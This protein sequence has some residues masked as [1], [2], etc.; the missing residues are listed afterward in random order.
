MRRG[1]AP[2]GAL[3]AL[4]VFLLA[5]GVLVSG[6]LPLWMPFGLAAGGA[7][8]TGQVEPFRWWLGEAG[9]VVVL[10]VLAYLL[11]WP[12]R[13]WWL[14]VLIGGI[15]V[16]V[17]LFVWRASLDQPRPPLTGASM[18]APTVGIVSALPLFWPEG[19]APAAQLSPGP[20]DRRGPLVEALDARAVD[21]IDAA[22]LSRLD[23]LILAQP[24]LLQPVELVALDD[25]IRKGGRA[26]VFADP[27]LMWP[28]GLSVADPRRAPLTSLLDPL[29]IHWGLRLE[30]VA[31]GEQGVRR[32]MLSSGHVLII[33]GA[34]RFSLTPDEKS[35]ASC[36]LAEGSLMALCKVGG[37]SVRLIADADML[38]DRLWLA[39]A[40]WP[41]RSEAQ[42]SDVV[43]LLRGWSAD[44]LREAAGPVPRRVTDEAALLAA[45]RWALL[46]A[47]AWVG[48]GWLGY[49]R[50]FGGDRGAFGR[51]DGG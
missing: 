17:S 16:A 15:A 8:Q 44:P 2:G 13:G 14:A 42:A 10:M 20:T 6:F 49:R 33:A 19:V 36:A 11:R 40:R 9:A 3:P 39:D 7:L 38:D 24:R 46:G 21:M 35:A 47:A 5:F 26:I 29:L 48:L 50:V 28:S 4:L 22:S 30:P 27:L 45:L 34:S 37:G 31:P 1:D 43:S 12:A 23:T 32:A 18:A 25:W 51:G 41:N